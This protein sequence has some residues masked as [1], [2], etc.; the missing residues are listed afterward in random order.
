MRVGNTV[1]VSG[2][3]DIDPTLAVSTISELGMSL[4]IAS[5]LANTEQCAGTGAAAVVASQTLEIKGD[6]V[7]DRASF[8]FLS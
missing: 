5:N 4:P 7:N 3:V 6:T 1:T 8:T 2:K